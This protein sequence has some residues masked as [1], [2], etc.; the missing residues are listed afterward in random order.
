MAMES[1]NGSQVIKT[2]NGLIEKANTQDGYSL[3]SV[4]QQLDTARSPKSIVQ[5]VMNEEN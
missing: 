4:M 5:N 3:Q 1:Q 2:L